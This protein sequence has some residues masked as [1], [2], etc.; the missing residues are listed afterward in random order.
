MPD[1][2]AT[3]HLL[4]PKLITTFSEGYNLSA[5]RRDAIAGATVAIVALPLSMAIAVASGVSPDRGLVTAIIGGFAVSALSGSRFQIGGP[6]GAF[7]TLVAA[8]V[9]SIGLPGL[10]T[11]V[12]LSGAMLALLGALRVGSLV[13]HMPH[14]VTVGFSAGIAIIILASQLK[15]LA[16][17]QLAGSEPGPLIPK[18]AALGEALGTLNIFALALGVGATAMIFLLRKL[19]PTWPGMLIALGAAAL[20][21]T[22][23]H[24]PVETIASRFGGIP[25]MLPP[26]ALPNLGPDMLQR[27]L[28]A[29]L[30]F[31]LLG[32]VES[33]LSAKVADGMTGRKHRSN[34]ELIGQGVANIAASFFGG[35]CVTGTIARTATNIRAG[36]FSPVSG[37]LHALFLLLFM[38]IAAPLAGYIPLAALAGVLVAVAWN[39]AE[40]AEIARLL[41][42]WPSAVVLLTTLIV[43]LVED[44]TLGII[45]GCAAAALLALLHRA[46][47]EEGA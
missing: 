35:I 40:K 36:A 24:L 38:L 28:P 2:T 16:G 45:A 9:A 7:I 12:L 20:I 34:M 4:R 33:L 32:A 46:P 13:R 17:L 41:R 29:A 18:L 10:L 6:A 5:L 11:A 14:A 22:L 21:A 1:G 39:M 43:T 30:S 15:D 47:P 25:H 37:I 8:T 44:L 26:P 31:T 3:A 27:A 42:S 23:A 19:R